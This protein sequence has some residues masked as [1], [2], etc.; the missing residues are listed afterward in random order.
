MTTEDEESILIALGPEYRDP[1]LGMR[2]VVDDGAIGSDA[3][4][5]STTGRSDDSS[6]TSSHCFCLAIFTTTH[7]NYITQ[8]MGVKRQI[9]P[10]TR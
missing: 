4:V 3:Y 8:G 1:T 6:R 10:R 5:N 2:R 7:N 9:Y